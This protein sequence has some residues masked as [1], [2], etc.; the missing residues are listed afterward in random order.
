[1]TG[2]TS[3]AQMKALINDVV[4]ALVARIEAIRVDCCY[5]KSSCYPMELN[6]H[7]QGYEK[8]D[9]LQFHLKKS[10]FHAVKRIFFLILDR[11][12]SFC[13]RLISWQCKKANNVAN[14]TTEAE[15]VAAANC[16]G[17]TEEIADFHQILDFLTSSS[18]NFALSNIQSG[19]F[20]TYLIKDG[21]AWPIKLMKFETLP[22]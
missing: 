8:R 13:K 15:Y 4:F 17:Q 5:V 20:F 14:S 3:Y 12:L 22:D 18:I 10:L 9:S 7:G 21:T 19:C 2:C 11:R 16:Y 1:M 6:R